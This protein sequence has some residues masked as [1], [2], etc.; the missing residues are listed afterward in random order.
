MFL[1]W[2]MVVPNKF[3][4]VVLKELKVIRNVNLTQIS[5]SLC[6]IIAL[7]SDPQTSISEISET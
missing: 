4:V 2:L 6:P 3:K 5:A 1:G 7:Q